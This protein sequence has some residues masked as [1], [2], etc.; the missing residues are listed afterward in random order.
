M[1]SQVPARYHRGRSLDPRTKLLLIIT[2][3]IVLLTGGYGGA[4]VVIRPCLAVLPFLLLLIERKYALG[5]GYAV[6]FLVCTLLQEFIIA[7]FSGFGVIVGLMFCGFFL[8]LA[9]GIAAAY[10]VFTTTTVNDLVAGL[11]RMHVPQAIVIPLSVMF[12]FVPTLIEEIGAINRAMRMRGVHLGGG[13]AFSAVE[14]RLVPL[15]MCSV[16]IGEEL[17]A[18]AL[19]RGLGAPNKR[20]TISEIGFHPLD[21]IVG[22]VCLACLVGFILQ[23]SGVL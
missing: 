6:V 1:S 20:T 10:Y 21:V 12:R 17:S 7:S 14:Y 16:R 9:P 5:F 18:A 19:T 2:I 15:M 13:K 3:A 4:M 23:G 22:A 11:E 8:R